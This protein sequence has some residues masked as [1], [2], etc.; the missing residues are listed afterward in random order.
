VLAES[1]RGRVSGFDVLDDARRGKW[2]AYL[3]ERGVTVL[4]IDPLAPLL[5]TYGYEE[6]DTTGV[7]VVLNALDTLA[8]EA[9]VSEMLVAHH[10]GHN[11]ERSRGASRLRDWPDAEWR[12]IREGAEVPGAEP[13]PDAARFFTAEGRDVA[14]GETRLTYQLGSRRLS[15]AGGNRVQHAA[16]KTS[17]S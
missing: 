17:R 4:I 6:N 7:A 3:R 9:G 11:G 10:M 12:L 15:I 2:A 1:F 5:A 16:T 14:L 8:G 13:P